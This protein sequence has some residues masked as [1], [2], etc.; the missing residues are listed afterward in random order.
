MH[1]AWSTSA[2]A[3]LHTLERALEGAPA[4]TR[5]AVVLGDMAEALSLIRPL[6]E[7][8]VPVVAVSTADDD[9]A[10]R[11]RYV[12]GRLVVP[13]YL[14][15]YEQ[16]SV[17][18]L[19]GLGSAVSAMARGRPPLVYG[20][21]AQLGMLYRHR[22]ELERKFL[23]VLN[24]DALAWSL[25]DKA[26]FVRLC[27]AAGLRIPATVI[28]RARED[29]AP[30]LARLRFPVVVRPR[31]SADA[32]ACRKTFFPEGMPARQFSSAQELLREPALPWVQHRVVV[33]E[34]IAA[35]A[36]DLLSFHGFVAPDGRL[37]AWFCGRKLPGTAAD[38]HAKVG[39]GAV[40]ELCADA[41]LAAFGREVVERLGLRGPFSIDIVRHPESGQLHVLEV[42]AHFNLWH[43]L[44]AAH[45]VN[46]PLLAYQY[47]VEGRSPLASP[48]YRPRLRWL[49]GRRHR[50]RFS[51][52]DPVPYFSWL[53]DL[54]RTRLVRSLGRAQ[55]S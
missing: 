26:R 14:P 32:K 47:L 19:L 5:P 21:N 34:D 10:F 46:L 16:T 20:T 11:S 50:A 23:L 24:D 42:H 7:N 48:R 30:A 36:Q 12:A 49:A 6:G 40:I 41:P 33:Q 37:L 4:R 17:D 28:P 55:R 1:Q 35:A 54:L 18:A 52:R 45:G 31:T 38:V 51:W 44:G 13:G 9:L 25:H 8:G 27:Q 53:L 43:H 29:L 2:P 3:S 39:G 22:A 15:P